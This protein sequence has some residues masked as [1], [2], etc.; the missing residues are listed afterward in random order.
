MEGVCCGLRHRV[1]SHAVGIPDAAEGVL[2]QRHGST[3][4]ASAKSWNRLPGAPYKQVFLAIAL[5]HF[6]LSPWPAPR[7]VTPGEAEMDYE[8]DPHPRILLFASP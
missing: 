8:F 6:F 5:R 1:V 7:I 4:P 3:L 2:E